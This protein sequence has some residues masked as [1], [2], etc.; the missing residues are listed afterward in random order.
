MSHQHLEEMQDSSRGLSEAIPPVADE[1][2]STPKGCQKFAFCHP[3]GVENFIL[4]P[5]VCA[6]LRPP[7]TVWQTSG[8]QRLPF[9]G[10]IARCLGICLED[11]L[12]NK[13]RVRATGMNFLRR[14]RI[15]SDKIQ[16]RLTNLKTAME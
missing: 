1:K 11:A 8:L 14:T 6:A 2:I 16:K 12:A 5:V 7:A 10:V 4:F 9:L 3:F 15:V 13:S